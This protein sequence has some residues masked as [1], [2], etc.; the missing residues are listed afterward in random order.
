MNTSE[1]KYHQNQKK[2]DSV[3]VLIENKSGIKNKCWN[4]LIPNKNE[5]SKTKKN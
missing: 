5:I 1:Y 2:I 4:K 3:Q